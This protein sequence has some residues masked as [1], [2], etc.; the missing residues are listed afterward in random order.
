MLSVGSLDAFWGSST[1]KRKLNAGFTLIELMIVVAIIGIL[2]VIAIPLFYEHALRAKQAE[3][4]LILGDIKTHQWTLFSS[5]D[6]FAIVAQTPAIAPPPGTRGSFSS[7]ASGLPF[8][9]G[10]TMSMEDLGVRVNGSAVYFQYECAADDTP[11]TTNFTCSAVA[12]LDAD[13]APAEFALCT[14]TDGDGLGLPTPLGTP[15]TF[16]SELVRVSAARL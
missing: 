15:C 4:G 12:D 2:A 3:A 1:M 11:G 10:N 8:C 6:C 5:R 7:A 16:I 14:D 13:G 9:A